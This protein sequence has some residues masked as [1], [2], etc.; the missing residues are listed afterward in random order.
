MSETE[1]G[2]D[3]VLLL[4]DFRTV[5]HPDCS[6]RI[7]HEHSVLNRSVF[8]VD[9]VFQSTG[10]AM[11]ISLTTTFFLCLTAPLTVIALVLVYA[12]RRAR[13][14]GFDLE[15]KMVRMETPA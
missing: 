11:V 5:V 15:Q 1:L 6:G 13:R 9:P 4:A 14:E 3:K 2:I 7:H 12:D 10:I 8:W